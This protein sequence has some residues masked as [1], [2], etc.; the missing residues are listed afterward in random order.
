MCDNSFITC[1]SNWYIHSQTKTI[2]KPKGGIINATGTSDSA[3]IITESS[4]SSS[5]TESQQKYKSEWKT[6]WP[7]KKKQSNASISSEKHFA[8]QDYEVK[9]KYAKFS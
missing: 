5:S 9:K 3:S 6:F 1:L 8:K 2:F 7:F 4:L